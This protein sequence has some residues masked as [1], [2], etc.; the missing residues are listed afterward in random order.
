MIAETGR[1]SVRRVSPQS[2]L[3]LHRKRIA[4]FALLAAMLAA[5]VVVWAGPVSALYQA[6]L[7]LAGLA[8]GAGA[9]QLVVRGKAAMKV[10]RAASAV[11][12]ALFIAEACTV[13]VYRTGLI[14][15]PLERFRDGERSMTRDD[16]QMGYIAD[17]AEDAIRAVRRRPPEPPI[18]DVTYTL[19]GGLRATKGDPAGPCTVLFMIDSVAFGQGLND[20][21]TLPQR[22]S[23]ATGFRLN[24]VN[25]GFPGYGPQQM[26]A[27][28]EGGRMDRIVRSPLAAA[29][30]IATEDHVLRVAGLTDWSRFD[31]RYALIGGTVARTGRFHSPPALASLDQFRRDLPGF[32]SASSA[33]HWLVRRLL[34]DLPGR[35]PAAR[36]LF[37]E[38]LSR[39]D[40][41]LRARYG[42]PLTVLVWQSDALMQPAL[43]EA[44][45][46]G[47]TV[48]TYRALMGAMTDANFIPGDGH[49]SALTNRL[50]G[51][52]LAK[53][54]P[55]C[56]RR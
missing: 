24:V 50:V 54:L 31:P 52:A 22:F 14:F 32:L 48:L 37:V 21:D 7:I 8:A 23:E 55:G 18:Y 38:V 25:L 1:D 9:P 46:R 45:R 4:A 17:V 39:T 44:S 33:Y 28:L 20:A 30:Y 53:R 36:A 43:A 27:W 47:M 11:A 40:A 29:Y 26:L 2:A 12:T 51:E 13:T 35:V 56:P 41:T 34:P 42:A 5:W 19:R 16:I 6:V 49:P 15:P 10:A 3:A